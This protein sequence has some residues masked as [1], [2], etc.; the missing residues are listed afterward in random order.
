MDKGT[1]EKDR[2]AFMQD[3]YAL[4]SAIV[5]GGNDGMWGVAGRFTAIM[6]RVSMN[7][8]FGIS[9]NGQY[10]M[11]PSAAKEGDFIT[12]LSGGDVP[13]ILRQCSDGLWALVGDAYIERAATGSRLRSMLEGWN[14]KERIVFRIK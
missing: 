12:L 6:Q 8:R 9:C 10:G 11:L 14:R 13:F 3:Y 4:R 2:D 5:G 1:G 7:R